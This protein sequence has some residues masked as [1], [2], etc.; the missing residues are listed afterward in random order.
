MDLTVTDPAI[1]AEAGYEFTLKDVYGHPTDV[2]IKVR[3]S[4]SKVVE[5]YSEKKFA[6]A[7]MKMKMQAKRGKDREEEKTLDEIKD[8]LAEATA[9][10]VISWSGLQENGK[11][12]PF[13]KEAAEDIFKRF[14][15]I[16]QQV[17]EESEDLTNF[18]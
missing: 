2:K 17:W 6:E 7:Q 12:I 18:Q 5:K 9:I 14:G 1:R 4:Y 15:W 16:R 3:G 10:R 8:E 13:S 11:D